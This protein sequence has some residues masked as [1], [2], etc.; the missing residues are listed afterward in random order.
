MY[1]S[2]AGTMQ[3]MT[4]TYKLT[5]Y[6]QKDDG[7]EVNR[8]N[9]WHVKAYLVV[10]ADGHGYY[11]Y[12]DDNTEF[13][14]DTILIRYNHEE[15]SELYKSIQFTK[16][17]SQEQQY[18]NHQKPG[19]G[20]EPTMGFNVNN[21]TF[22]YFI[23]DYKPSH[24]GIV[25]SYY[26]DV[27]Y[28]KISNDT[29]LSKIASETNRTLSPLPQYELKNL[30]G[31]LIFHAGM[32]NHEIAPEVTNPQYNQYKYYVVDFDALTQTA[33]IYYELIEG[34]AGA[35]V[36]NNVTIPV[37][38]ITTTDTNGNTNTKLALTF[39]NQDY[40]AAISFGGAPRYLNYEVNTEFD[41]TGTSY[42]IYGNNFEKYYDNNTPVE[43]IVAAQLA[44]YNQSQNQN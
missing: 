10:G 33:D 3:D 11:A 12:Q 34:N 18:I 19:N 2:K 16:G 15:N 28:T 36:E 27:V 40:T 26:T 4:G 44:S 35:Q 13:W 8:I 20:Y 29:D 39:F 41:E 14:Y 7:N 32:P 30:N 24:K 38:L 5:T 21:K 42:N 22:N 6:T 31:V 17:V 23:P 9:Q 37:K 25:P 43:E 1:H